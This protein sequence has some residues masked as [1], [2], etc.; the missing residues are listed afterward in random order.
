MTNLSRNK[1]NNSPCMRWKKIVLTISS[2]NSSKTG[3]KSVKRVSISSWSQPTASWSKSA[4]KFSSREIDKNCG[5]RV[6]NSWW[7]CVNRAFAGSTSQAR[8]KRELLRESLSTPGNPTNENHH[9]I[10]LLNRFLKIVNPSVFLF[11]V[12]YFIDYSLT[13]DLVGSLWQDA[14]GFLQLCRFKNK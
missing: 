10:T 1:I 5:F 3:S 13:V 7:K 12:C 8:R 14:F 11:L 6:E 4:Y 2:S 9:L